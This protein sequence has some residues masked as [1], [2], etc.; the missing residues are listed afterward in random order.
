MSKS[1]NPKISVVIPI[2]NKENFILRVLRSIQ[3]QSFK[4]IEIVFIDDFA[5]EKE[6]NGY[7]IIGNINDVEKLFKQ[8]FFDELIIGIG[9]NHLKIRKELL[10]GG[11]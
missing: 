2:Y 1:N 8:N 4:D 5:T 9:Y 3:N 6:K 11:I 10:L 7:S